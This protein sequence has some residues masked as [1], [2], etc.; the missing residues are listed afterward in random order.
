MANDTV[1]V[2]VVAEAVAVVVDSRAEYSVRPYR[3]NRFRFGQVY[4]RKIAAAAVAG[5]VDEDES[6]VVGDVGRSGFRVVVVEFLAAELSLRTVV[7]V[8]GCSCSGFRRCFLVVAVG[9][10]IGC[11]DRCC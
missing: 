2:V 5:D 1:V 4:S 10:D 8:A 9:I 7:V 11:L 6:D 3:R